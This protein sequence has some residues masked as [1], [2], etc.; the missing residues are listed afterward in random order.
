MHWDGRDDSVEGGFE[1][2]MRAA[3]MVAGMYI[4]RKGETWR[5]REDRWQP[6]PSRTRSLWRTGY[7]PFEVSEVFQAETTLLLNNDFNTSFRDTERW[8]D[9]VREAPHIMETGSR[10]IKG[11]VER[12][13]EA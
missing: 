8:V 4:K 10:E 12:K 3:L 5:E 9:F 11:S 2:G 6:R 13:K 1:G 7:E